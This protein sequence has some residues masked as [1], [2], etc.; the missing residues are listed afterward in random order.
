MENSRNKQF[1]SS[2]SCAIPSSKVL[3]LP[4]QDVNQPFVRHALAAY[5]PITWQVSY[6]IDGCDTTVLVSKGPLFNKDPR[7]QE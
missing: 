4:A 7:V 1:I 3:L 5:P 6:Q 2:K